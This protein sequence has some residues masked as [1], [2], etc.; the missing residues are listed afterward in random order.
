[1]TVQSVPASS[2]SNATRTRLLLTLFLSASIFNAAQIV[3]FTMLPITATQLTGGEALAGLPSTIVLFGRAVIAY[4]IGWLMDKL[5]RRLGIAA[6]FAFSVL[7]MLICVLAIGQG[8]FLFF[9]LGA[10]MNGMG[11][12]TGEQSRYAAADVSLPERT[13]SAVGWI[14]FA[15]TVGSVAGPWLLPFSEKWAEL[16]NLPS[17]AGPFG[18]TGVLSAV[19]CLIIFF[20]LFP[21]PRVISQ[22]TL[23][24]RPT[25]S[26]DLRVRSQREIFADPTVRLA[27]VSL[28]VSQLVMTLIMVV[29]PLHM[30]HLHYGLGDIA[31]VTM[32]HTLGM[33]LFAGVTGWMV[34]KFG[35]LPMIVLGGVVLVA[36]AILAPLARGLPMLAFA[37]FLLGLGWSFG[38]VAG[39][40]LLASA[41]S[42]GE[43]SRT[44]GVSETFVA[45][46][47]VLGS[48]STGPAFGWGGMIAVC[49][50]GLIF[51]LFMIA[52]T[53]V[54]QS[55]P[56]VLASG[57]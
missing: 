14:V 53:F 42:P 46:A 10:L 11:R 28:T 38:Y 3:S 5:G 44:Q 49:V 16:F 54:V 39:S 13:A 52:A 29:N 22:R 21:D 27:M 32:A 55:R 26:H 34:G 7:G 25:V 43:R 45:S 40:S 17:L 48:I 15:G 9:C 41:L 51:S 23:A 50:I 24:D 6:G 47:A 31:F 12:G 56:P 4:P 1:M 57:D 33:F 19:S 20:L 18:V 8:S 30:T 36:A 37:L 2:V 35:R